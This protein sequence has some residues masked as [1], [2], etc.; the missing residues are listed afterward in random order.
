MNLRT[1]H[2]VAS[3]MFAVSA[4]CFAFTLSV[5]AQVQTETSTTGHKATIVTQVEHGEVVYVSGNDL[6]IRM[7]DGTIRHFANV[8]ESARATVDGKQLG[9][10]DLKPGMKLQRSITTTSVFKT[11]T[12]VQSVTGK[13]WAISPPI[14]VILTLADGTNQQFKIPK[15][16][17]FNVDG[18][19]VDAW[20]LKKGMTISATKI[21][22]VPVVSVSERRN[23]TGSSPVVAAAPP[24]PPPPPDTPIL[25]AI[26]EA[27]APAP[28][29]AELPKTASS[30][31][32]IGLLG[33][34]S[35]A[36]SLG[37]RTA[38]RSR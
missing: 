11:I 24:P 14:S 32:L 22:E 9:I 21:V 17:K 36:S 10:H 34:L 33:L 6:V 8:P 23:V 15:N 26:T 1:G 4:V 16:Q 19:M 3:L 7:E 13:V 27:P 20:G 31:P 28:A 12:T 35:L 38:R 29:S 18:Q 37:L 30:L 2:R 5:S 25:V